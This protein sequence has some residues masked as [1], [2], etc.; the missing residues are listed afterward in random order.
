MEGSEPVSLASSSQSAVILIPAGHAGVF[1]DIDTLVITNS[2]STPTTVALSDNEAGGNVY[3]FDLA[4]NGGIVMNFI[5]G[6]CQQTPGANWKVL[7]SA[8]IALHFL[9]TYTRRAKGIE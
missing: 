5:R 9:V 3:W 6:L 4:A 7:N 8:G 1:N 2:T